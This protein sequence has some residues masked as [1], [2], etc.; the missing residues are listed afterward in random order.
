MPDHTPAIDLS[1]S[2][3]SVRWG[4]FLLSAATLTF[5][6][7]LTRLF[8]VTQF[9]HFAFMIVSIALLGFGASGTYLAISPAF[10]IRNTSRTLSILALA[11]SISMLSAFILINHVPFDSFSIAWDTTQVAILIIHY[12]ALSIPF[13]FSGLAIGYLLARFPESSGSTYATNLFG[14]ATGCALAL[15]APIFFGGEGTTIL[16]SCLAALASLISL[17]FMRHNF[18]IKIVSIALITFGLIISGLHIITGLQF[19]FMELRISPYKSLSYALQYPGAQIVFQRWNSFSRVDLVRSIGIRSLPGLSYRYLHPPPVQDGLLVDADELSPVLLEGYDPAFMQYL[20]GAI[21]YELLPN[22][23]V[24]VMEPR[25]GLDTLTA[26]NLGSHWVTTVESNPLIVS[27]APE[28]YRNPR[29]TIILESGRSYLRRTHEKFDV[30]V[31]SLANSFHPVRSGAYSLTEDYRYTVESFQDGLTHLEAGGLFVVTRWIQTP[32]SESLRTFALAITALENIGQNPKTQIVAFRGYNTI[33]ILVKR[34]PFSE[35]ELLAIRAFA[36]QRAFDLVY[37]PDIH[38]QE[39]N[40]YNILSESIYYQ[41]F[42]E[43][44]NSHP[45]QSFYEKY[46]YEVTPPTDDKPFFGHYF[47][48]SQAKQ[49]IAELG[50]TMQPFG[51]AGYFVI[52]ALLILASLLAVSL[53]VLP[54]F[55][56]Q[57]KVKARFKEEVNIISPLSH[58]IS[59]ILLY[60]GLIGF[61]FFFVEIPLIQRFIL[62]LGYPTYSLAA[63]LFTILLFSGLGSQMSSRIPL[64]HSLILLVVILI[65]S[66]L[67]LSSVFKAALGQPLPWRIIITGCLL[68][69]LGFLMGTAF[70]GG[71]K[72]MAARTGSHEL[73]PWVWAVN[74]ASSVI[75]SILAALLAISAG[76]TWVLRIGAFCYLGAWLILYW[77]LS[78]GGSAS[79]Q[80]DS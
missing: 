5:E 68:A 40:R 74:G 44:L 59:P 60:F 18:N 79:T 4:L 55:V 35:E 64:R 54:V 33:T 28:A 80:S 30:I 52:F 53:I 23:N 58:G 67:F 12:L 51:G 65:A 20:P 6:I 25:G 14:A 48:W 75:A 29:Q 72:W 10:G 63:V 78:E 26:L 8:S 32:P 7:N 69:P 47:K 61:A 77:K 38:P 36:N 24:L 41:G 71:I 37:A 2:P 27:A 3:R 39:T 66:P 70:P 11:T 16:S 21:A 9:Y 13:F 17:I 43:L 31:L 49:I 45:R 15:I 19:P 42:L 1:S 73:I 34:N 76:F 57:R 50:K 62:F 22:A 46:P 56:S